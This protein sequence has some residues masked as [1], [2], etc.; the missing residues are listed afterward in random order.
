MSPEILSGTEIEKGFQKA[1]ENREF[2]VWYQPQVDMRTGGIRGAEAL[3]RWQTK[4]GE[5]IPPDLFVPALEKKGLM[6]L[7]DEEVLRIVCGDIRD[8]KQRKVSFCPVSV[9]LSRMHAG[10][11]EIMGVFREITE[12][13]G[14]GKGELSFEI[15]ETAAGP[16]DGGDDGMSRLVRYLR[17]KGFQIAMD[18]YGMGSSTLKLLHE[19]R[20]DILKLDRFFVSRIG[21]PKADVILASTIAMAKELGLEVVAEGVENRKQT[22]FLLQHGCCIAQGYYYSRPLT[23]EMYLIQRRNPEAGYVPFRENDRTGCGEE[24]I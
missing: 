23:K 8:A 2:S 19:I 24:M 18:D 3:V 22:Q 14:I 16:E 12:E 21:D 20:F 4:N 9:N 17:K 10:R 5:M 13:Y 1:L 6:P 11:R 15:T 7:L